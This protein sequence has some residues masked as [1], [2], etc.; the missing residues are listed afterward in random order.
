MCILCIPNVFA[1]DDCKLCGDWV[2]TCSLDSEYDTENK[3]MIQKNYKL[4]I[5]INQGEERPIVRVKMVPTDGG[6]TWYLDNC[7]IMES[8]DT[9]LQWSILRSVDTDCDDESY[10]EA[11]HWHRVGKVELYF[12][13]SVKYRNSVLHFNRDLWE[14]YYDTKGMYI[15][16]KTVKNILSTTLYKDG[17]DW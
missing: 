7:N 3:V 12:V 6:D 4:V 1:Q 15:T 9:Y 13:E 2:G 17:D 16:T 14:V 11:A 8:S 10:R 5:R